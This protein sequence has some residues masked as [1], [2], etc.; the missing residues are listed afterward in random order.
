MSDLSQPSSYYFN[1]LN[2]QDLGPVCFLVSKDFWEENGYLD[3]TE[4][5]EAITLPDGFADI[6]EATFEFQCSPEDAK[7]QMLALGFV[8]NTE[9][10]VIED[11]EDEEE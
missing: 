6:M 3:D 11:E 4:R 8:E 10:G 9:V 5:G 2:D 1:V 7:R